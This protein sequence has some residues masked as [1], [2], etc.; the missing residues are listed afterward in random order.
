MLGIEGPVAEAVGS[1]ESRPV[2]ALAPT[3]VA[4]DHLGPQQYC[5]IATVSAIRQVKVLRRFERPA[6]SENFIE[7]ACLLKQRAPGSEIRAH[8]EH[9]KTV[10]PVQSL[11]L[12]NEQ[13]R[14]QYV[15]IVFRIC[16]DH[17]TIH[18]L[19]VG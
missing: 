15:P 13:K 18:E 17:L 1:Q 14:R 2:F 19:A 9:A 7:R 4:N 6:A 5:G 8:P 12:L 10:R 3:I 11:R 16:G